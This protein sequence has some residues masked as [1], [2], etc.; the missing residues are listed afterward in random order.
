MLLIE[1]NIFIY[2]ILPE[3][4]ALRDWMVKQDFAAAE[5]T[6]VEVLGY[7]RLKDEDAREL[8]M[9]FNM[10][11]IL[12]MS[13]DITD[14]AIQLRRQRKMGLADAM[15]AATALDYNIPLVTR[16]TSDYDWIEGLV[17]QNPIPSSEAGN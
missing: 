13:R 4:K 1:S 15:I 10:A 5:I 3:H 2:A 11:R 17:L 16:N 8:E 9:L 12:P 6:L 14:R 7:H